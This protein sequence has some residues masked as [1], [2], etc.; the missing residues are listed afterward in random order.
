M[1]TVWGAPGFVNTWNLDPFFFLVGEPVVIIA[2]NTINQSINQYMTSNIAFQL[3]RTNDVKVPHG[4]TPGAPWRNT[5]DCII[6]VIFS[7]SSQ[8]CSGTLHV[9]VSL[10]ETK[11]KKKELNEEKEKFIVSSYSKSVSR[12]ELNSL[13]LQRKNPK[14]PMYRPAVWMVGGHTRSFETMFWIHI[15]RQRLHFLGSKM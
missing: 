3:W 12:V 13:S 2:S 7:D 11:K 15:H 4:A 14:T 8:C 10:Q 5:T 6:T 1:W 9:T